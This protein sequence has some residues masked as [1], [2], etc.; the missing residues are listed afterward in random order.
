MLRMVDAVGDRVGE[1]EFREIEEQRKMKQGMKKFGKSKNLRIGLLMLLA[2][3]NKVGSTPTEA[4]EAEE[5]SWAWMMLCTLAC[6]EA[7]SLTRW[8]WNYVHEFLDGAKAFIR[9]ITKAMVWVK[10]IDLSVKVKRVDQETQVSVP[11]ARLERE[12][13]QA[14]NEL[15][16]RETY[17]E[18][19]EQEMEKMKGRL[20]EFLQERE[21]AE[22]RSSK[23]EGQLHK[24]RMTPSGRVLHFADGCPHFQSG[25]PVRLCTVCLSEGGV[26]ESSGHA[27]SHSTT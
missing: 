2:T 18:E 19:L 5:T 10:G 24:L 6:I 23:L 25:Q 15:F 26:S 4:K 3:I 8:L 14:A 12:L 16:L 20:T 21:L 27:Y 22:K 1:Q 13:E 7:L 17:I 9:E 11:N